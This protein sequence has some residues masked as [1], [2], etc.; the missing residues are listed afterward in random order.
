MDFF[1]GSNMFQSQ[2]RFQSKN[3]DQEK[4]AILTQIFQGTIGIEIWIRLKNPRKSKRIQ[5]EQIQSQFFAIALFNIIIK[6]GSIFR[7]IPIYKMVDS[8]Q[9]A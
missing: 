4:N 8:R 6:A 3:E 2:K 9:Q 7:P 5:K 1:S